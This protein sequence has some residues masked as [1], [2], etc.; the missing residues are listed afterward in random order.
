V[1]LAET[2]PDLAAASERVDVRLLEVAVARR[3][4]LAK[5]MADIDEKALIERVGLSCAARVRGGRLIA[6]DRRRLADRIAARATDVAEAAERRRP[7]RPEALHLVRIRTKKLRQRAEIGRVAGLLVRPRR[8]AR[9]YQNCSA[10]CT[11]IRCSR[12]RPRG[13]RAGFRSRTT[14]RR[15]F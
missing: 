7:L 2:E 5:R 13:C 11:T 8:H 4:R 12:R 6:E 10:S 14:T 1:A 15:D 3:Q 9:R